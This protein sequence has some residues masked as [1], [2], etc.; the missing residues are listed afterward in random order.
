MTIPVCLFCQGLA[1]W[2]RD[3]A[4]GC[5]GQSLLSPTSLLVQISGNQT[6]VLDAYETGCSDIDSRGLSLIVLDPIRSESVLHGRRTADV[7]GYL[8][9]NGKA[10]SIDERRNDIKAE[11]TKAMTEQELC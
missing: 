5:Q 6:G 10:V 8:V 11:K 4:N 7:T 2:K 3:K 1:G 9:S